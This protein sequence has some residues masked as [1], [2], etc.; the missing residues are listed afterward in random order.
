[1]GI[2]FGLIRGLRQVIINIFRY[3]PSKDRPFIRSHLTFSAFVSPINNRAPLY[4]FI[5][6][7]NASLCLRPFSFQARSNSIR[8]LVAVAFQGQRPIT[9]ALQI[10]LMRVHRG[11]VRL[12]TLLLFLDKFQVKVRSG[13]GDRRIVG[14]FGQDLLLL[15]LIPCE[16]CQLNTSLGIRHRSNF[17]SL[18]FCQ[19]SRNNGVFITKDFHL[20]R[21]LL[22]VV[23][24][25]P[26]NMLR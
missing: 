5:R 6:S 7:T 17:H 1:M 12:P 26:L 18:L 24:H 23:V 11:E 10:Q 9:R 8:Q 21:L 22:C 25:F 16:V 15:G 3:L 4:S 19:F 14:P 2:R 13:A 20:I